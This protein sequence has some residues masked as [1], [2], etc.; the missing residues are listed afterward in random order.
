M[1]SFDNYLEQHLMHYIREELG[2]GYSLSSVEKVLLGHGHRK[3]LV[4]KVIADLKMH[5]FHPVKERVYVEGL[6]HDLYSKVMN[7]IYAYIKS[8][9][10]KGYSMQEIRNVLLGYGH[11]KDMIEEAVNVILNEEPKLEHEPEKRHV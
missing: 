7:A 11:S 2:S 4:Q 10:K 5:G 8:Q 3:D 9:R 6:S 1:R